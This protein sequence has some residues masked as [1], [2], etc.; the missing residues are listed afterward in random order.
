[1]HFTLI[2]KHFS[3]TANYTPCLAWVSSSDSPGID[4]SWVPHRGNPA[5][6]EG[7]LIDALLHF[8]LDQQLNKD[9][10][11]AVIIVHDSEQV[12]T[13]KDLETLELDCKKLFPETHVIRPWDPADPMHKHLFIERI[14]SNA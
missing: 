2:T 13:E 3:I 5:G 9:P 8:K 11:K 12:A 6:Q 1:M 7:D 10:G 14:R 4:H